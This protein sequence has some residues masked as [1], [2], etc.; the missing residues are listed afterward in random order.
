MV[1]KGGIVKWKT[2]TVGLALVIGTFTA[3]LGW[4]GEIQVYANR[5]IKPIVLQLIQRAERTVDVQMYTFTEQDV[6]RALQAARSQ[7]GR[8]HV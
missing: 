6:I 7:I 2:W 1:G 3:G 5:E 4:A 8:A